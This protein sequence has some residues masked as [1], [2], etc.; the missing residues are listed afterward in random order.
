MTTVSQAPRFEPVEA[1]EIGRR[2]FGFSGKASPLPSERDQNFLLTAET[3]ERR[4]LKIANPNDR[5]ED[6]DLQNAAM[7]HLAS[8]PDPI[9]ASRLFPDIQGRRVSEA[10][11]KAGAPHAVRLVSY[12]EGRPLAAVCPHTT[13]LLTDLG[14]LIGRLS[15]RLASFD[16]PAARRD[17]YW[18]LRNGGRVVREYG[19]LIAD[20]D[21]SDLAHVLLERATAVLEP[22]WDRLPRS[23]VYNDANDYNVIVEPSAPGA[24]GF[25]PRR[26]AGLIDFGDMVRSTTL[27]EPAVACAY[28]MLGKDNPLAA[29]R[30]VVAGYHS[31]HPL[32]ESDCEALFPLIVLRLLMSVAICARQAGLRPDNEY[33]RISNDAAWVLLNRLRAVPLRFAEYTFRQACGFPAHPASEKIRDWL[34]LTE[35]S[36]GFAPVLGFPLRNEPKI[37]FDLSVGTPLFANPEVVDDTAAWTRILFEEMTRKG[38][39]VGIGRADEARIIYVSEQFRPAGRPYAEGRTVHLGIDLFAA[40][41]TPVFAPAEGVVKYARDNDRRLDYGPTI[42]LEHRADAVG[43]GGRPLVYNTLYGHLSRTSLPGMLPGRK[44]RKGEKI[45]SIGQLPEN[46]DW[47]PHLHFQIILDLFDESGDYPGVC[48][49][50]ERDVWRA[51]CPDPNLILGMDPAELADPGL[52]PDTI[53]AKRAAHLGP[54]LSISYRKPLKIVRGFMQRLYDHTGRLYL[55]AVNNVP[56]VGHCHP[57]VVSAVQRQA[58]VLNTNTRYL[59]DTLARYVERLAATLPPPLRVCYL[60]NSGS[61]ANDLA[62]RLA[63]HFTGRADM[64]VLGGAYHG[65]LSSLIEISPYKFEAKGGP[66][67]PPQTQVAEMPDLYRGSYRK[68]DSDA[69]RKYA[70][71]VGA[72]LDRIKDE[73]RLPAGFIAESLLSCGGQIVLPDGYLKDVYRRVRAAGGICIADE[74]QVGFG[75]VGTHFWGFQ[76][77]G[78][79]PDIV[80]MGKPI[81]NGFPLAAVVTT[82]A[83]ADAFASGPEYFNTYGGNPVSLAAGMA[84][85]DVL[86]EEKLQENA[87]HVGAVLKAGLKWLQIDHAAIGDVRG[88]GL[89]VG[90][91]LVADRKDRRPAPGPAAYVAERMREEGILLSVDGPD[92]NVLKIKPPLCFTTADAELLVETLGRI[93]NEAPL[94]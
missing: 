13:A 37:V 93:L 66:G 33:L 55:D 17:F 68:G 61:E 5:P 88:S 10:V 39:R 57:R 43:P 62:L 52:P 30:A 74:V 19:S 85:L 86:A 35:A 8:G 58:A 67:R 73:G 71:V 76:T 7:L 94:C 15:N 23:V 11:D 42:I 9:P 45:G 81:G 84:V 38:A 89:F 83:I 59:H 65:H 79:V 75:R 25:A 51:V 64:V 1:E 56:H 92:R 48:R 44:I 28:A 34:R 72:C 16:H 47:P 46:G 18:D 77:Q 40:A 70:D 2:L 27:A 90:V 26:I 14:R 69:G 20:P 3:G 53:L 32:D 36:G 80:T 49:A 6:L 12:I 60:V 4:V 91:E 54:S 41:G 63:R 82:R 22:M 29:A 78:V 50:S 87:L 24:D 21:R 31:V